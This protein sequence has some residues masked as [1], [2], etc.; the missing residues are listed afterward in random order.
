M[1]SSMTFSIEIFVIE[2]WSIKIEWN[3][4]TYIF[5]SFRIRV[6]FSISYLLSLCI[7]RSSFL[8]SAALWKMFFRY[9]YK[10]MCRPA[11]STLSYKNIVFRIITAKKEWILTSGRKLKR[12]DAVHM[13][14]TR[15]LCKPKNFVFVTQNFDQ[16]ARSNEKWLMNH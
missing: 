3:A 14:H 4:R 8:W 13:I 5:E 12:I 1:N 15:Q 10:A 9:C 11:Y 7:Q 16:K 2:L 6:Q